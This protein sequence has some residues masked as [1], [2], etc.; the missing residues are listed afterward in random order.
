MEFSSQQ[1]AA[2]EAVQRWLASD[3]QVFRLFGYAGTGKTTLAQYLNACLYA[4]FTGK[5]AH[6]L[7][8]KGCPD[9]GTIHSLIYHPEEKSRQRLKELVGQRA[10]LEQN[11]LDDHEPEAL[12]T[13]LNDVNRSIAKEKANLKRL[14]FTLNLDSDLNDARLLV[15]D[16]CSMVGKDIGEDLLSFGTK[17]LVLGDP[18]QL[19]PVASGGFFTNQEPDVLLTEVHRQARENPILEL[20][21]IVRE[22]GKLPRDHPCVVGHNEAQGEALLGPD[23]IIV[24]R[25]AT[26]KFHNLD[27]RARLGFQSSLP[28]PGDRVVCLRNNH[29]IGLLNG[30]TYKVRDVPSDGILELDNGLL[31]DVHLEIF[32]DQED[33]IPLWDLRAKESFDYGYALTCHKSQG[34]QWHSVGV[35]NESG[36][37]RQHAKRWLYTAITRASDKLWVTR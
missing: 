12:S 34:S 16:E 28:E 3:Q 14:A 17:I 5:A 33:D 1:T 31:V 7:R 24:G 36:C 15:I 4:A 8:Q 10:D 25:N 26:R 29:Q 21:T 27:M 30:A 9:A 18:A 11:G 23:Q 22:T 20:A 35:I 37:F 32:L 13:L 19:P 2:L 6:V